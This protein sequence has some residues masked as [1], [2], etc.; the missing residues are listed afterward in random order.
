MKIIE[1]DDEI[2]QEIMTLPFSRVFPSQKTEKLLEMS[3]MLEK[4]GGSVL[5]RQFEQSH[6][7]YLL[8]KGKVSLSIRVDNNTDDFSV[9]ESDKKFT[10]V[11]W[12]GFRSPNR[13][14]TTVTCV[15]NSILVKW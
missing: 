11:G 4:A 13:Y 7:F 2:R 12:S 14:A 9:G 8:L 3:Q 1:M 10:P 5:T 6:S 15:E